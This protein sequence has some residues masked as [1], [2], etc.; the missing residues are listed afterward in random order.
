MKWY[1]YLALSMLL[2]HY[3]LLSFA[4]LIIA[5]VMFIKE[6]A[7]EIEAKNKNAKKQK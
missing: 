3:K 7:D 1:H 5:V 6:I 4:L 2:M